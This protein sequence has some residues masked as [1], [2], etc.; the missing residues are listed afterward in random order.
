MKNY[1]ITIDSTQIR[2]AKV[3]GKKSTF[4]IFYGKIF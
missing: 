4:E 2:V 3:G 1:K